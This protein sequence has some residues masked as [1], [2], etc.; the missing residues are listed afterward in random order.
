MDEVLYNM[1][2]WP[3]IEAICYSEHDNP[4]QILGPHVT[5]KGIMIQCYFPD[6]IKVTI[7]K[8]K[9]KIDMEK[10]DDSGFFAALVP[11]KKVFSYSFTAVYEKGEETVNDPYAFDPVIPESERKLF[12][13]GINYTIYEWL[14][15]HQMTIDGISGTLFAVWAPNCMRISVVG[16][17]NNWN[18]KKHPMRRL[19]DSGIFEL[20]IPGG[21]DEC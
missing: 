10:V 6:A 16:D 19:G 2:N 3:E 14:G 11:G 12:E 15:A 17:F 4:H 8:G 9:E 5:D 7:N 21:C 20:F 13:A 18:G 1:M